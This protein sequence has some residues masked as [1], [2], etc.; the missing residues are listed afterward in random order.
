V[1]PWLAPFVAV[2]LIAV[3][4]CGSDGHEKVNPNRMLLRLGDLPAGYQQTDNGCGLGTEGASP[5]LAQLVVKYRPSACSAE[6]RREYP[7]DQSVANPQFIESFAVGFPSDDAAEE[8][9][10]AAVDLLHWEAPITSPVSEAPGGPRLGEQARTFQVARGLATG[11]GPAIVWR[12]GRFLGGLF[13]AGIPKSQAGEALRTYATKQDSHIGSPTPVTGPTRADPALRLDDP[14]LGV[15]V[16]WL[17]RVFDPPGGLPPI[18]LSNVAGPVKRGEGPPGEKLRIEYSGV[19]TLDTWTSR[20]WPSYRGTR[21]GSIMVDD[22]CTWRR[23]V[24]IPGGHALIYAGYKLTRGGCPDR[25]P[26][27]YI[28]HVFFRDVVVAVNIPVCFTCLG[29]TGPYNSLAGMIAIARGLR[30]KTP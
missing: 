7:A 11:A 13:V 20:K 24:P 9:M 14:R 6:F 8:G 25:P 3:A 28:A 16:Y 12:H 27:Q 17:G 19:V 10:D 18:R 21:F 5:R 26:P 30:L 15:P 23:S 29:N 22:P 2:L 4:G 1:R